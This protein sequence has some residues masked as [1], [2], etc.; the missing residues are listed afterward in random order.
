MG[1]A[2]NYEDY[3]AKGN[4]EN[5]EKEAPH[6]ALTNQGRLRRRSGACAGPERELTSLAMSSCN[7]WKKMREPLSLETLW[8]GTFRLLEDHR[9]PLPLPLFASVTTSPLGT[10]LVPSSQSCDPLTYCHSW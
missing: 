6:S 8:K 3:L 4:S 10:H 9:A 2:E 1:E 5:T 7:L